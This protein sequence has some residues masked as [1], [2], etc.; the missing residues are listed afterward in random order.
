MKYF[1]VLIINGHPNKES[2]NFGLAEAYK[3]GLVSTNVGFEEIVIDNLEFEHTLKFGYQTRMELEPDLLDAWR[4][5]LW[6]THIVIFMPIWWGGMP[7]GLKSFFERLFLPGMAFKY[8]ENSVWWDK[9]LMG[10]SAH[11]VVTLDTPYWYFKW[12]YGNPGIKQLKGNILQF[13]G[14]KPVQITAIAPIKGSSQEFRENWLKKIE[15]FG[16][17]HK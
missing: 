17:E 10:K 2:F 15:R 6:A 13:C 3:K 16:K 5:I 7:A 4:K 1:N 9:L 14:I 8:R 12:I 11:I